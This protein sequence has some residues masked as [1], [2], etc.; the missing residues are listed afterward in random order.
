MRNSTFIISTLFALINVFLLS[1]QEHDGLKNVFH[2]CLIS[3]TEDN[4]KRTNPIEIIEFD[5]LNNRIKTNY[6][7][8]KQL[9]S[10]GTSGQ[11]W[12]ITQGEE[13]SNI[14][15]INSIDLETGWITIGKTFGGVMNIDIGERI[16]FFNPFLNYEIINDR[17]LFRDYPEYI[18]EQ[19]INY[20]Q[21]GGII[22]KSE[23]DY[24]LLTPV[25]FGAHKSRAIYYASSSNLEDWKFENKLLLDT[26]NIPFAKKDGNVFSS[27]N[28]LL[29]ENGNLLVLLSI[30]QENGN[31]TS[32]FMLIDKDLNIIQEPKEINIDGWNGANQNGFPLSVIKFKGQYRL[33]LHR[34]SKNV[35]E[36]EIHEFISGDIM[37][38]LNGTKI[39]SS[40]IIHNA[41][42]E[43]G[44]L[45]GKADD[46]TYIN[47]QDKLYLLV[48]SE[49]SPSEYLTSLNRA[50]GLM[51]FEN[52][53]WV[54]DKRSPILVNPVNLN[55]KYPKYEWCNDHLG[56]FIS[57]YINDN[58]LYLFLSFGTDNPDYLLSGI[59][60]KL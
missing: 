45:H 1:A 15:E 30:E 9:A 27:G 44:Y 43:S 19:R 16:E 49:E 42:K 39:L 51:S 35:L 13:A 38:L 50:Y 36:T 17:P 40:Q 58:Y 52:E 31:Y 5:E 10:I 14:A 23:N 29:I 32:G 54:H 28:P 53:S 41:K 25:V 12:F 26:S 57:P 48:G 33:L 37:Q 8:L 56:G 24:V 3:D 11:S 22:K 4:I 59:K 20:I 6:T 18:G 2:N 55:Q 46:A 21:A 7:E 60:I 47:Y 34:R